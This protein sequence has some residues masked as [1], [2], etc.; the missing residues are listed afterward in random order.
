MR[1]NCTEPLRIL[2]VSKMFPPLR[3]ARS[4][5]IGRVV[6]ALTDA[7]CAVRVV[8]GSASG[9]TGCRVQQG[10]PSKYDVRFVEYPAPAHSGGVKRIWR[11]LATELE[12]VNAY[13][14]WVTQAAV[15]SEENIRTFK[16]DVLLTSST[17]FES[18]LVGM[19]L[20]RRT[21]IP[22]V[23][24]LS[25]P[26]PPQ[27]QP[28]PYEARKV[29]LLS[30][31]QMR[32]L[33]RLL[34]A[35]DAIH[36]PSVYGLRAVEKHAGVAMGEKGWAIPHIGAPL[37]R[38]EAGDTLP[39]LVHLGQLSRERVSVA[40]LRAIRRV[41]EA[42]PRLFEG[43]S[44]VGTVCPEFE[45]Q[46][47][48]LRLSKYIRIRPQV[49]PCEA[50]GLALQARAL[51]VI[52]ADMAASPFLPSK[53]ADYAFAGR[54]ILALTPP[55]SQIRDYLRNSPAGLAVTHDTDE[56]AEAL[57][58]IFTEG[59]REERRTIAPDESLTHEFS[60]RRVGAQYVGMLRACIANKAP[61]RISAM[62]RSQCTGGLV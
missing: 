55:K 27:V 28:A 20:K 51:L 57:L 17:P 59:Y 42:R 50:S 11:H 7:G 31:W 6:D 47:R 58:T 60:S 13:A 8:A 21:G 5:Q 24:S 53:F 39:W 46:V 16:P 23:A 34:H 22:W 25:D 1:S 14:P 15:V 29:P 44:C 54:P 38:A 37:S 9:R 36:M 52:E 2:L 12:S 61:C 4:V 18:H 45:K 56:I 35:C 19:C 49:E 40:L 30:A 33:R 48:S 26:W 43:L 41:A 32:A 62:Q 10:D 3:A